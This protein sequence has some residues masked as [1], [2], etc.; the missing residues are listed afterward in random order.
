MTEIWYRV[1][2]RDGKGEPILGDVELARILARKTPVAIHHEIALIH[3]CQH[4]DRRGP[5]GPGWRF[6]PIFQTSKLW[7]R[8]VRQDVI[9]CSE[10]CWNDLTGVMVPPHWMDVNREPNR[11]QPRQTALYVARRFEHERKASLTDH[12]KV[13]M[14]DWK[15]AGWCKWCGKKITDPR[16]RNWHEECA[17]LYELHSRAETQFDYLARRDGHHCAIC[18]GGWRFVSGGEHVAR[19]N[20]DG[21]FDMRRELPNAG[22]IIDGVKVGAYCRVYLVSNDEGLEVDHRRPLWSLAHLPDFIRRAF[23]GPINLWLLCAK[24]HKAKTKREA[25]ERAAV[26]RARQ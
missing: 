9:V 15:G 6:Y 20:F 23:Y 12:R 13:P 18:K 5:W 24:C 11:D 22:E 19:Y 3:Q 25:A 21:R 14:I 17:Y 16:R 7:E 8:G 10:A 26:R 1:F 2:Y 4:C